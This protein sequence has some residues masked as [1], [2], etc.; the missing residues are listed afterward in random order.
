[1]PPY[2]ALPLIF[3]G[4]RIVIV[5]LVKIRQGIADVLE[6]YLWSNRAKFKSMNLD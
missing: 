3:L 2:L 6:L 1:L 4:F 5:F